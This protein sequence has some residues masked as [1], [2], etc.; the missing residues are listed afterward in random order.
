MVFAICRLLRI[1]GAPGHGHPHPGLADEEQRS[2]AE[3]HDAMQAHLGEEELALMNQEAGFDEI[4]LHGVN[5]IVEGHDDGLEIGLIKFKCEEG[6]GFHSGN[7]DALAGE[8]GGLQ[9]LGG[10]DDRAV[11][12]AEAGAAIEQDV[13]IPERGVGG[14]ADGG[15]VVGFA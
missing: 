13:L 15:D 5:D 14:E 3:I 11:A 9:G 7:A 8:L 12:F 10:D 4:V 6:G 1:D 2:N